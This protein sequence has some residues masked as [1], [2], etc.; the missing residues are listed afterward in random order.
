MCRQYRDVQNAGQPPH[1]RG[2]FDYIT[3]DSEFAVAANAD[4]ANNGFSSVHGDA[5]V[6]RRQAMIR[7]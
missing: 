3:D 1:A 7:K 2:D 6:K 5:D 4:V